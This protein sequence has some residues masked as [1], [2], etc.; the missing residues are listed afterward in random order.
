MPRNL[1]AASLLVSLL[2]AC[3]G[4]GGT[5]PDLGPELP[6][7]SLPDVPDVGSGANDVA[8]EAG[9]AR[10]EATD[11]GGDTPR[12]PG[13]EAAAD[14]GEDPTGDG[15][16]DD[17]GPSD[18][19]MAGDPDPG[20]RDP[21]PQDPGTFDPGAPDVPCPTP[22]SEGSTCVQGA[23]LPCDNDLRCGP[24]CRSC[25]GK[26]IHCLGDHCVQCL[27]DVECPLDSTC[28]ANTCRKCADVDDPE[29]C[30]RLCEVCS[31]EAPACQGGGCVCSA[32]SC[33]AGRRCVGTACLP[34][35]VPEAC[36]LACGAC[37]VDRPFCVAG[38]R[39]A[40]CRDD[41]DCGP[42]MQCR[43]DVCVTECRPPVEGCTADPGS[44]G[45]GCG[46]AIVINRTAA[47]TTFS[48]FGDTS[49]LGNAD[50]AASGCVEGDSSSDL[51]YK[52]WLAKGESIEISVMP[53]DLSGS[54]NTPDLL[55][56]LY[57][58]T[59]CAAGGA[60]PLVCVD[61][62]SSGTTET[63]SHTAQAAGWY[64]LIVDGFYSSYGAGGF[65]LYVTIHPLRPDSCCSG[66]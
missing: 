59:D 35:N 32:G 52:V 37:G 25:S 17:P 62:W 20:P 28:A 65:I 29:H 21:G 42:G 36:G 14:P 40:A 56:K 55:L 22:C 30:G 38:D 12:D 50:D 7:V 18:D 54:G 26:T 5:G 19:G 41:N 51:T 58:G 44:T 15:A 27:D 4:A 39:C 53:Y 63:L 13:S 11:P 2:A 57:L 6:P 43:G 46:A 10:P 3:G 61:Q 33:R 60:V 64:P 45:T 23:C 66:S 9:D 47:A 1:F 16:G 48:V 34:C 24:T 8:A 49:Y 31:G